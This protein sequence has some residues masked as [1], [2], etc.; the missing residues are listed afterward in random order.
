MLYQTLAFT[1][2]RPVRSWWGVAL[3]LPEPAAA[4][5]W[6]LALL[7]WLPGGMVALL[8]V[9]AVRASS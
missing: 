1:H 6:G 7:H 3:V 2:L 5:A 9:A 8:W 4:A